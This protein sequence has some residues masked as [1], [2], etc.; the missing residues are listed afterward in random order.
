MTT[1]LEGRGAAS[2]FSSL[3]PHPSSLPVALSIVIVSW[4]TADLLVDCLRTVTADLARS[5]PDFR[6]EI[7]VVDN[8]STDGSAGRVRAE[9]PHVRVIESGGN[10]G[11][12]RGNNLALRKAQGRFWLL[13]NSDTLV[14]SRPIGEHG[15]ALEAL[16]GALEKNPDAA[17]A[18]PLLLNEDGSPQICWARFQNVVSETRGALDR[19]QSPYPLADFAD[20]SKRA[21]MRPFAVDWVGGACFLVR[22]DAARAVGLLD[23]NFFMYGEETEWCHRL[24]R[25]NGKTLLVP[26]VTVTHLGGRSSEAVPAATRL[27]IYQ[28]SVR[29]FRILYGPVGS[30]TPRFVAWARYTLFGVKHRLRR[31]ATA[32]G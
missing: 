15:G 6:A 24:G 28:S 31:G 13:L 4:N 27:R 7:W 9:L 19:S 14:P 16:V 18:S 10:I 23:E 3:I 12:A 21:E 20:A 25:N 8:A 30:L 11:F 1:E 29:L 32:S 26:T 22:A 5:G 2:P 17:V